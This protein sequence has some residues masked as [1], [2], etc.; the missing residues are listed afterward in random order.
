MKCPECHTENPERRKFCRECGNNLLLICSYCSSKN[1][2]GDKF[3]GECGSILAHPKGAPKE[4]SFDEKIDKIQRFLPKGVTEKVISQKGNIEGE[5]KQVTVMFCDLEGFTPLVEKLGPEEAYNMMDQIYE[6]LIHKVH[7]YEGTVNEM[8]GDGVMALFGAPIALEDAPQRAIRSAMSIHRELVKFNDKNAVE[9]LP[10]L[11]MRI[12]IHTGLVV[13]GALGN[14]L[15][16]EFKAVGDTVNIASRVEGLAEPGTTYVTGETYSHTT[17]FFRFESLGKKK[18]KGKKEPVKLYRAITTSGRRTRFDVS[19]ERGLTHFIGRERELEQILDGFDRL[20]AGRGQVFS[21]MAEAGVGKSRLLYEFRKAVINEEVTFLE[22]KC[23]SYSSGVAYHPVIDILK[24]NFDV[25]KG[26]AGAEI[27]EKVKRQLELIEAGEASTLPYILDLLSV[28]D[29]G[30]KELSMSFAGKK[31]RIIEALKRIVLKGS[32]IRPLI[33]A[34]EDL[35][36]SDKGSE[37]VFKALMDSIAGA[38]VFL[39][40]T[41]RPEFARSWGRKSFHSY[42]NLNRL[43]NRESLAMARH[44]LVTEH[45]DVKLERFILEKTE[46]VPFFIEEFIR[47]ITNLKIIEKRDNTYYMAKDTLNVAIPSTIQDVI[48]ARVDSLPEGSKELLQVGSIIER[49]FGYKIVKMVTGFSD[50]ELLSHL[51]A[52]QDSELIYVRGIFPNST[53]TFKHALT[54]DVVYN[55]MLS[56]RRMELHRM[57]GDAIEKSYKANIYEHYEV[58]GEHYFTGEHNEKAANYFK[59]AEKKAEKAASLNDAIKYATKR[60]AAIEKLSQTDRVAKDRID[61]GTVLG[62]YF[63]QMNHFSKAKEAVDPI[64]DLA[65]KY[66]YKKRLSQIYTIIGTYSYMVEEDFSTSFE[67]LKTALTISKDKDDIVSLFFANFWIGIAYSFNCEFE[68]AFLHFN[69]SLD[70]NI[71]VNN[72]W[73]ISAIKSMI[74]FFVYYFQ[75]KAE[76]CFSTTLEAVEMAERSGDVYSKA[77]AYF[78]HGVSCYCIGFLEEAEKNLLKGDD[79]C[80]RIRFYSFNALTQQYL[81]EIYFDNG[82]YKQ[83]KEHYD[84]AIWFTEN[85]KFLPSLSMLNRI[86]VTRAKIITGDKEVNVEMLFNYLNENKIKLNDSLMAR[87]V[88]NCLM[89]MSDQYLLDAEKLIQKSIETDKRNG[90]IFFTAKDYALYAEVLRKQGHWKNAKE[91]LHLAIQI[92]KSCGAKGWLIKAE[93]EMALLS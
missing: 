73:G 81:G 30:I 68:K 77:F 26:D 90:M 17:G 23:L 19:A 93:K 56:K 89:E 64:V 43:S 83:S 80:E 39:L 37:D 45:L 86:G 72:L 5:R 11:K 9:D 34:V 52:L 67:N 18:I 44:L 2:P 22:G 12:G 31:D 7:E 27:R 84:K 61:A 58:L 25:R 54:R 32:E 50:R 47:S 69:K 74:N 76:L 4:L 46:G 91:M 36:W 60:V 8:T 88:I 55:S 28:K 62:L 66:N 20:K 71:A 1:I 70:I 33:I 59:L 6:I 63:T 78:S 16:V 42:V 48:M 21:I 75:G 13:V 35:H 87:Y 15:R 29:S 57:V 85:N 65:L 79:F 51:S 3:C 14:D 53:N 41:Y 49:E 40:F 38:K 24:A 82:E 92:Y 10:D